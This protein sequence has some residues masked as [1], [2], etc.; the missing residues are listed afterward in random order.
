QRIDDLA[1]E[2]ILHVEQ[3]VVLKGVNLGPLQVADAVAVVARVHRVDL[4]EGLFVERAEEDE[5]DDDPAPA[6]LGDEVGEAMEVAIVPAAEIEAMPPVRRAGRLAACPGGQ[7]IGGLRRQ[8]VAADLEGA[9][10]L[11]VDAREGARE[12]EAAR[13]ELVEVL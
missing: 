1:D 7:V 11:P 5:L 9:G 4:P 2:R 12:V 13:M 6:R 8:R 10:N 3:A